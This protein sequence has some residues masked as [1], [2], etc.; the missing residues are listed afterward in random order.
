MLRRGR[1]APEAAADPAPAAE[2]G[3]RRCDSCHSW[4][5]NLVPRVVSGEALHLCAD[6]VAC[7]R[8]AQLKRIWCA[9]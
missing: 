4:S 8:R 2:D 7:R 5:V 1:S 9:A 6:P 3:A